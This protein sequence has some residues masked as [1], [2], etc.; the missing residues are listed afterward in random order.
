MGSAA[1]T[2]RAPAFPFYYPAESC[3]LLTPTLQVVDGE[4]ILGYDKRRH[5]AL[6]VPFANLGNGLG[7]GMPICTRAK[8]QKIFKS[9]FFLF[10]KPT[11]IQTDALVV[12]SKKKKKK[13]KM[14]VADR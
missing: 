12:V 10:W 14:S 2:N 13:K 7:V 1:Q 5:R 3:G 4:V 9:I 8:K 11:V 6:G